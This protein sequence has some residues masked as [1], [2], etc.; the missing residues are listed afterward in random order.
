MNLKPE[1]LGAEPRKIAILVALLLAAGYFFISNHNSGDSSAAPRP[2]AGT[3]SLASARETSGRA[4]GRSSG[5]RAQ[6]GPNSSPREFRPSFK[7]KEDIDPSS[8]DPTLHLALLARLH[9]VPLEPG[10][11]SLFEMSAAPPS[12]EAAAVKNPP[13][14]EIVKAP[15]GPMPPPP[16]PA[17]PAEPRAPPIQLKFYG[18]VNP[19]KAGDRRAFFLDGEDIIIAGEGETIKKRYKIVRIGVNSAVVD[20]TQFKSN[21]EQTLPLETEMVG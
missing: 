9:D 6:R 8:I 1:K 19:T 2:A 10:S 18:F 21:N 13:N 20:D 16:P 15:V 11:R 7:A 4:G 17:P 14:I 5:K 12:P 3:A